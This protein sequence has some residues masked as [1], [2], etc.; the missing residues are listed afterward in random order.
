M[1]DLRL[2]PDQAAKAAPI[3]ARLRRALAEQQR[4]DDRVRASLSRIL[5]PLVRAEVA[6][7][8]HGEQ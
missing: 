1:L 2:T 5:A 7:M 8:K 4:F 3:I 6:R